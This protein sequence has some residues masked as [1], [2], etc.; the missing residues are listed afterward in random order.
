MEEMN[1]K[2]SMAFAELALFASKTVANM[3]RDATE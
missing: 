1:K 3:T 2:F